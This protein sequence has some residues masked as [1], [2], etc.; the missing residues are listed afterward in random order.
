[1]STFVNYQI[2]IEI[3]FTKKKTQF[4]HAKKK[5][6][7]MNKYNEN[8]PECVALWN[9]CLAIIKDNISEV[10][11]TTWFEPIVAEKWEDRTL[12]IQV[13]S[14]FYADFVDEHY[15]ELLKKTFDRVM[16]EGT[17]LMYSIVAESVQKTK[18][19]VAPT[20]QAGS[21]NPFIS[22]TRTTI[23][24][25]L[26]P[27][28]TFDTFVEGSCN[29]LG[30]EAGLSVAKAPFKNTFNP[31]FI[32]GGSGLGKTHLAHAIGWEILKNYP[33]KNVL[34][35]DAN[36]FQLQYSDAHLNNKVNDFLNFYQQIDVL[37]VDDI[38][39]FSGKTGTQ[40]VFFQI[41]NHLQQQGKQ[42]ILTS[43]CSPKS[44]QGLDERMLTRFRWG[45]TVELD[46]PT[47]DTRKAILQSKVRNEGLLIPEAVVDYIARNVT[48]NIRELEGVI[49]SLLAQS[50]LTKTEIN[51]DLAERVVERIVDV[52]DKTI[53]IQSIQK[54]VCDYYRLEASDIQTKSRKREVV[55]ARQI[56]MY[57]SRKYT[58][59]SLSSIGEQIGHRDHATVLYACN[60]VTDLLKYDKSFRQSLETI[61]NSLK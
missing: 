12:T 22:R 48:D 23:D 57:L 60:A 50:T 31:L 38:Q 52:A 7:F 59:N 4:C 24:P 51:V 53:T 1:M 44:L 25:Q 11:F 13:P 61:E 2:F 55:Q 35:V 49:V 21:F 14:Q 20:P 15:M 28:Y 39:F 47:Q 45:L 41:F 16:G 30:T 46:V 8:V 19:V 18:I 42:I 54:L 3:F 10:Q 37:I 26:N 58:K 5:T 33:D 27:N 29:K 36:R 40:N 9:E 17:K 6:K 56:A 34:Y 43:D 32:Y